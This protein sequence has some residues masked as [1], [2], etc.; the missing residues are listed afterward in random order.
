MLNSKIFYLFWKSIF[1]L[2][3]ILIF[4]LSWFVH[5]SVFA[6]FFQFFP[7]IFVFSYISSIYTFVNI[8]AL[9]RKRS[10]FLSSRA[11]ILTKVWIRDIS[12]Y[13]DN[14]YN[15]SIFTLS[16][17]SI[18]AIDR[19]SFLEALYSEFTAINA[20]ICKAAGGSGPSAECD[21]G[22]QVQVPDPPCFMKGGKVH[23]VI[24][25]SLNV[26]NYMISYYKEIIQSYLSAFGSLMPQQLEQFRISTATSDRGKMKES[27]PF[28]SLI[29]LKWDIW[30]NSYFFK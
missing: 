19:E 26:R 10:V 29:Y 12:R 9:I 14:P 21:V 25:M 7:E 4:S 2:E 1:S 11:E 8:P 17:T 22:G 23:F 5:F 3:I 28:L 16:T 13:L 18:Q 20:E 6:K 27:M 15:S 30:S 24:D